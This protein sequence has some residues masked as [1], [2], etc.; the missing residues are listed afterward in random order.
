MPVSERRAAAMP[1][2]KTGGAA[3]LAVPGAAVGEAGGVGGAAPARAPPRRVQ[4]PKGP[5]NFTQ[6]LAQEGRAASAGGS[7]ASNASEDAPNAEEANRLHDLCQQL[8]T[9]ANK[10]KAADVR[11]LLEL[12]APTSG[13]IVQKVSR[14]LVKVGSDDKRRRFEHDD[15]SAE[16]VAP[17]HI[18]AQAGHVGCLEALLEASAE[19]D[20][21]TSPRKLTPLYF[22]SLQGHLACVQALIDGGA[23]VTRGSPQSYLLQ[24]SHKSFPQIVS[25]LIHS[26]APVDDADSTG[27]TPLQYAV[28]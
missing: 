21:L 3:A 23:N 6:W 1:V 25:L 8:F 13:P 26:K 2:G 20:V 28:W 9:A 16:L 5:L 27:Q 11:S 15:A 4:R 10:G 7:G 24:S 12:G 14:E 17:M 19:V 18:A 22:A